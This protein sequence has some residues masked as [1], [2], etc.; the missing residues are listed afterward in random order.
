MNE[1]LAMGGYAF[2]VWSSYAVV[3]LGLGG[4]ALASWFERR[5]ALEALE[6]E[7]GDEG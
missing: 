3:A 7:D 1:F 5:R 6:T 2:F 4:L